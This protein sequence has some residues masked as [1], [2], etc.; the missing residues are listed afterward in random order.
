MIDNIIARQ[1]RLKRLERLKSEGLISEE[2]YQ[3]KR[4]EILDEL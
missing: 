4:Q 2:E 3:S 1:S